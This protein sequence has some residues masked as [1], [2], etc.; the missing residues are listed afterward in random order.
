[1]HQLL[2]NVLDYIIT[3]TW[4]RDDDLA[5]GSMMDEAAAHKLV[6]LL[7]LLCS[8]LISVRNVMSTSY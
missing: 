7:E 8:E 3:K 1:M 2:M 5:L 4:W 6:L